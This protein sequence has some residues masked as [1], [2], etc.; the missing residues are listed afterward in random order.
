MRRFFL[1]PSTSPPRILFEFVWKQPRIGSK[2]RWVPHFEEF[3]VVDLINR[4]M[5][6]LPPSTK[7]TIEDYKIYICETAA[8]RSRKFYSDVA[9]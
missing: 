8:Q 9:D 7:T 3:F 1:V 6:G 5:A 4:H 2:A